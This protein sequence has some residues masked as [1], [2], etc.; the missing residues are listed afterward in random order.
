MDALWWG[1]CFAACGVAAICCAQ[2]FFSRAPAS[3]ADGANRFERD[4]IRCVIYLYDHE[5]G[6]RQPVSTELLRRVPHVGEY[7]NIVGLGAFDL[8]EVHGTSTF[9]VLAV[10]HDVGVEERGD[11]L[12]EALVEVGRARL[13]PL[14]PVGVGFEPNASS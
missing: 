11:R 14:R 8:R 3:A 12:H 2:L 13:S 9:V 7:I 1:F 6:G 4:R 5:T 10:V